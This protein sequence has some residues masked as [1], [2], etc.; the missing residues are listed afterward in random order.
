MLA[1]ASVLE[2]L[3]YWIG[4]LSISVPALKSSVLTNKQML[5]VLPSNATTFRGAGWSPK[6]CRNVWKTAS[7]CS[8]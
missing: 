6:N 5:K 8:V 2:S 3:S 1:S 4:L 7:L